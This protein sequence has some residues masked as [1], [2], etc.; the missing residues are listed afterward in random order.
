[1]TRP[2]RP[3]LDEA[4]SLIRARAEARRGRARYVARPAAERTGLDRLADALRDE[5]ARI[6]R[7]AEALDR[8]E[9]I[10]RKY[11]DEERPKS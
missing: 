7:D 10:L 6:R 3:D 2:D 1:M 4:R 5:A 8:G 9:E 11:A